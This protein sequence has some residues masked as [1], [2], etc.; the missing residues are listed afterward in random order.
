MRQLRGFTLIELA[1][2]VAIIGVLAAAAVPV[3]ELAVQRS[4]EH[5]LRQSLRQIRTAIDDYKRAYDQGRILR[6]TGATGYPPSLDALV[7]GV[8]DARNPNKS[9]IYFLRRL[10]RDPMETDATVAAA[11]TWGKRAYASPP[12]D[13]QEGEDVFDVYSRTERVG[14]NGL[15][16]RDW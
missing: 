5:Q 12:D 6:R 16:Y 13:P 4:R 9:Q 2:V 10:P 8:E 15:P 1:V 7:R 11:D 3:T 14:L